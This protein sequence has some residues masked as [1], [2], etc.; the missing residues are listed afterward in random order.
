[1]MEI[2]GRTVVITGASSGIGRAAAM[3]FARRRARLV[4]AA[5]RTSLL[6][7]VASECRAAGAETNVVATDVTRRSDCEAL[8]AAAGRVD[9]LV[10]NAGFGVFDPIENAKAEDLES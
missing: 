5:R 4:L 1:M 8:I 7:Q 10:N 2:E 3:E 9:I 6:D